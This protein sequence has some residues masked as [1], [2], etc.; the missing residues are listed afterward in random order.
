MSLDNG[1]V[2][3][4]ARVVA[5]R[6]SNEICAHI[7]VQDVEHTLVEAFGRDRGEDVVWLSRRLP[8]ASVHRFLEVI[9]GAPQ[10]SRL[11]PARGIVRQSRPARVLSLR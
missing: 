11:G 7:F 8:K 3:D 5:G 6:P 9:A 10:V 4:L 2:G 1:A